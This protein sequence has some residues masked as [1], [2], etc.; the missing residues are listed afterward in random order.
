MGDAIH[1]VNKPF[2]L[3]S[4]ASL[5]PQVFSVRKCIILTDQPQLSIPQGNGII[6]KTAPRA[7]LQATTS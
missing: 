1:L 5:F 7:L 2:Y 4:I 3:I 6:E